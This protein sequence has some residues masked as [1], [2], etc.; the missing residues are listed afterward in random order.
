[1]LR[2][3]GSIIGALLDHGHGHGRCVRRQARACCADARLL[4]PGSAVNAVLKRRSLAPAE[5]ASRRLNLAGV[6]G[7][8]HRHALALIGAGPFRNLGRKEFRQ[9]LGRNARKRLLTG[10]P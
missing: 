6:V 2:L 7:S 10:C 9:I 5:T 3:I 4:A 1:M 8:I